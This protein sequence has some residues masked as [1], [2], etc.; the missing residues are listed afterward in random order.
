MTRC[1]IIGVVVT[2]LLAVFQATLG[3]RLALG[4][5]S[6][7]LLFVWSVSIGLIAGPHAGAP[8][9]FGSGILEGALRQSLIAG[10]AIGKGLSGF[11]AGI[12]A[13]KMFRENWIVSALSA[14]L[15]TLI[16]EGISLA[17]AGT[18]EWERVPT[19]VG[20]RML[21]HAVL[22]PIVFAIIIRTRSAFIRNHEGMR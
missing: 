8:T 9:G 1:A 14:A 13:S 4:G 18:D 3:T 21:Y 12:F 20:G 19:L 17:F 11:A 16:N 10:L 2:F 15:L 5:I 22:T 7:D 6:P